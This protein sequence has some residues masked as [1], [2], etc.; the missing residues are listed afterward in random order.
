MMLVSKVVLLA[1]FAP[2]V[3]S[4]VPR[5]L[6]SSSSRKNTV[7]R[8]PYWH[9]LIS[10]TAAKKGELAVG[11]LFAEKQQSVQLKEE[12]DD[13]KVTAL[14]A[15][16]SRAFAGD[17]EYNNL[18]L[19]LAAIFGDLPEGSPVL[20]MLDDA[21]ALLPPEEEVVGASIPLEEREMPLLEPW[22]PL[23]GLASFEPALTLSWWS[24]T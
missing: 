11:P 12:I 22:V 20:Q 21:M 1:L 14:F 2:V 19:A 18:M 8:S 13:E 4:F 16:V 3:V 10:T 9:S 6:P 23:S 17:D 15:W 5:A 24:T 7:V